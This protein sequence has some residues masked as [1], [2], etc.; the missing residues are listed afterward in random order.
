MKKAADIAQVKATRDQITSALRTLAGAL[1]EVVVLTRDLLEQVDSI[2]TPQRHVGVVDARLRQGWTMPE[3][4]SKG[5]YPRARWA[6]LDWELSWG[7][8]GGEYT[9]EDGKTLPISW[10]F[11]DDTALAGHLGFVG[12][13]VV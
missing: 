13:T 7:I 4:P 6:G 2:Q 9:D 11:V 10:P 1:G 12:F 8:G 3:P 5:A